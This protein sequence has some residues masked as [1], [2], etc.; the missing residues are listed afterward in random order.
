MLSEVGL[1]IDLADALLVCSVFVAKFTIA[2][3]T[4]LGGGRGTVSVF[5]GISNSHLLADKA[6][7]RHIVYSNGLSGQ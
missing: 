5:F 7:K 3:Q 2:K 1:V 6:I 4:S